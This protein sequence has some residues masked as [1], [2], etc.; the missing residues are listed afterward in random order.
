M[1]LFAPPK[2]AREAELMDQP[3]LPADAHDRALRG[4]TRINFVSR[5]AAI[6]WPPIRALAKEQ[7]ALRVLDVA[8]GGGD[9]A[10]S[11]RR[12][13]LR[14]GLPIDVHG[15]D[16]SAHAI[17]FARTQA[18]RAGIDGMQFFQRDAL[19]EGVP[20]GYD[21]VVTSLFLHHLDED[22][23][24]WLLREMRRRARCLAVIND[25]LRSRLGYWLAWSGC[26]ILTRSP[27][28]RVDGPRSVRSAYT[29]E[30]ALALARAAGWDE[31]ELTRHWPE[32]Y[33]MSWRRT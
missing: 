18:E 27:I 28:V 17:G 23:A 5:S 14:T 32:R 22:S 31:P 29:P 16:I 10:L 8:C 9:V 1:S 30:E 24:V 15:C 2:R 33:R 21:V 12:C 20:E 6:L 26:R 13:A 3:D 25:L 11:L 4:L 19:D 7:G